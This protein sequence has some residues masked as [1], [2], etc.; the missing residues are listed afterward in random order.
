MRPGT[1]GRS[2]PWARAGPAWRDVNRPRPFLADP[3]P[4]G[5]DAG[6]AVPDALFDLAVNRAWLALRGV[7]HPSALAAWHARTRFARRVP[8][9][10]VRAALAQRPGGEDWHWAG[11][12]LGGWAAGKG[13][14]P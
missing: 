2:R 1:P 14:F 3:T 13:R 12:P 5:E 10:A 6:G 4:A 8:L 9:D 7:G 11:G